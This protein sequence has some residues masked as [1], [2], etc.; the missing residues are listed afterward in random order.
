MCPP[1]LPTDPPRRKNTRL[2]NYD[3]STPGMY[4]VTLCTTD[5]KATFGNVIEGMMQ[6]S[7]LGT[8]A[9][10]CWQAIPQHATGVALDCYVVMPNHIHGLLYLAPDTAQMQRAGAGLSAVI[11]LYKAAVS[12]EANVRGYS[13]TKP[14][15]QRGFYD[16]VVRDDSD[17]YRIRDYIMTNPMR[18][19]LDRENPRRV[20]VDD[21]DIWFK[22]QASNVNDIRNT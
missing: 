16:H 10:G 7:K 9:A 6:P 13:F 20:G 15:W 17:L 12:R 22:L 3:Y 4:F 19:E 8:L 18:W 1:A 21:F 2:R 14:L 5:R 11:S